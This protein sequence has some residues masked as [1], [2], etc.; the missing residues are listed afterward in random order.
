M[1]GRSI[2]VIGALRSLL[3]TY[4]QNNSCP[5]LKKIGG[6]FEPRIPN[7]QADRR[8]FSQFEIRKSE[9]EIS[10]GLMGAFAGQHDQYRPYHDFQI[11]NQRHILEIV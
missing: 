3:P 4:L 2:P 8:R 7:N 5:V 6:N 9:F 10:S 1:R 11:Q